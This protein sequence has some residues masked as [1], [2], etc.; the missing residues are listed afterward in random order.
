[1]NQLDDRGYFGRQRCFA[2][3]HRTGS[4]RPGGRF[5]PYAHCHRPIIVRDTSTRLG[6]VLT[7]LKVQAESAHDDVIDDD[8]ILVW[9]DDKRVITGADILGRLMRGIAREEV[10]L[11]TGSHPVPRADTT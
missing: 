4:G 11:T 3:L 1:M 7:R 5:N 6:D 8:I 9:G 2:D 10:R